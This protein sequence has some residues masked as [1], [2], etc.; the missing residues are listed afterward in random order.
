MSELPPTRWALSGAATAGYASTFADLVASGADVDGE[1]RLA[2][3]LLGREARVLDVGSGMG[4]VAAAL[5]ARGHLV[6][7]VEPDPDL[8]AQSR[9][10]YPDLEVVEADVLALDPAV[11]GRFDLVVCVGNVLV[12]LA[13]GTERRVLTHLASLLAP[14]GRVLAGF[15]LRGGPTSARRYPPEEFVADV[16]ASGLVVHQRFGTY[17]LHPPTDDYAVWVL[18]LA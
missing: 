16:E 14:G 13:D 6:S 2:D 1:A 15:H 7:A 17:E 3:A 5:A 18:A 4:R 10:T 11:C 8:V 9:S 12:F